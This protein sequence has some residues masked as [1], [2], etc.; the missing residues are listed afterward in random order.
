MTPI[1]IFGAKKVSKLDID[2]IVSK[3]SKLSTNFQVVC[4]EGHRTL[5]VV[6]VRRIPGRL[7]PRSSGLFAVADGAAGTAVA[8]GDAA[9]H[10]DWSST[11]HWP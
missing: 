7:P 8:A 11:L 3:R 5:R 9:S 6:D 1:H 2:L 10:S 4:A